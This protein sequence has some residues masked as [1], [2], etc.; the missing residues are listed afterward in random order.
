MS[1]IRIIG[2]NVEGKCI[3]DQEKS[4]IALEE[5]KRR[6]GQ[7][8]IVMRPMLSNVP[9]GKEGWTL[10]ACDTCGRECWKLPMEPNVLPE[11]VTAACTMCALFAGRDG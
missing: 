4:I 1:S 11:G 2:I 5:A 8:Q 10:T 7:R 6:T 3:A 9:E